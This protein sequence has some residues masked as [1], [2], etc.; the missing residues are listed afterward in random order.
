MKSLS[1]TTP[2][3]IAVVGI[4]GSGKTFFAEKFAE[5]FHAPY[6]NREKIM[7]LAR[8]D[9]ATADV[10]M[11]HELDQLLKTHHS[12]IFEGDTDTRSARLEL[13]RKVRKAGYELFLVWV[14]TDPST[15]KS[16]ALKISR[17][18]NSEEYDRLAKRF[19]PPT[20]IEKPVVISG[21]HTYGTQAKA[22][23]QRLSAPR[24]EISTHVTPPIR[25]KPTRRNITIR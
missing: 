25:D 9:Q 7:E 3:V 1:L 20:I 14:Q 23:L 8:C 10:I 17:E 12:I 5:T 21:R 13:S 22:V 18:Q 6:I 15:A 11:Q 16:R 2:H 24:A 19:T 4:P